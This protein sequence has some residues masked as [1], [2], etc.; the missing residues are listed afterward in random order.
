V[1][2]P[3][4]TLSA[5]VGDAG[6]G[7]CSAFQLDSFVEILG[8][9]GMTALASDE[10]SGPGYCSFASISGL[11]SGMYFVRV[12]PSPIVA[13]ATFVYSLDLTLQ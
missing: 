3:S 11:A 2:G 1:P 5:S 9:D 10:D 13:N 8:T 6:T 12:T 7:K 4:S